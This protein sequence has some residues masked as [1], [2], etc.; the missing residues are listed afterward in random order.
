MPMGKIGVWKKGESRFKRT[1]S[2]APLQKRAS[3]LDQPEVVL[4]HLASSVHFLCRIHSHSRFAN[5]NTTAPIHAGT[6]ALESKGA[7]TSGPKV[8]GV[9]KGLPRVPPFR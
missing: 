8:T 7:G 9:Q 6:S 1:G 2:R 3:V 4:D 5:Y